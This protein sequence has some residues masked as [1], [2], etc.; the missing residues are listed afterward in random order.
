MKIYQEVNLDINPSQIAQIIY[1][2]WADEDVIVFLNE[3]G[4]HKQD[5]NELFEA[6]LYY[7]K[8]YD[9]TGV[10]VK[11]NKNGKE[12]LDIIKKFCN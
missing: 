4:K 9:D 10:D 2:E 6:A 3:L 8:D 1:N 5:I 12:A 7:V 11:L